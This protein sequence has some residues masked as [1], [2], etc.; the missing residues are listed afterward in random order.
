MNKLLISFKYKIKTLQPSTYD[1]VY[2]AGLFDY[3]RTFDDKEKG[4]IALTKRLFDLLKPNGR[5][6]IGN[7]SPVLSR[8]TIWGM[9]CYCDW[10]LINRTKEEVLAFAD[11][12]PKNEIK[13]IQVITEETGINWFLDIR[14]S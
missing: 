4:T 3:I 12:I 5:L 9:E 11:A 1:L 8:G 2:S 10:Y 14:K 13:S 7:V 6:L